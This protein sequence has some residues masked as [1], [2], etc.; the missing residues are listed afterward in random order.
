MD[1]ASNESRRNEEQAP[2]DL[3]SRA[4]GGGPG[5]KI[6]EARQQAGLS[7]GE[8]ATQLRLTVATLEALETDDFQTLREPV[9]VRGYY[10][11]VAK[12][13]PLKE[14]DLIA[15]YD[16]IAAPR[17]AVAAMPSKLLLASSESEGRG[18][19]A[20]LRW[21]LVAVI[22][23]VLIAAGRLLL[24]RHER[25]PSSTAVAEVAAPA[26]QTAVPET[27]APGGATAAA[28]EP[29]AAAPPTPASASSSQHPPAAGP[30]PSAANAPTPQPMS[31][32]HPEPA[33]G[34][35]GS[36]A[37]ASAGAPGAG[38]TAAESAASAPATADIGANVLVL[39]FR[40][41]SWAE[42][43]DASG[44]RLLSG[45]V[46]AGAHESLAGRLPYSVFLGNAPK[47]DVSFGG[48][49]VDLG[50]RIRDNATARFQIP[51]N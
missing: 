50:G 5:A 11:K 4:A 38:A 46:R 14:E 35:A 29:A 3:L 43:F 20:L 1:T 6:R 40:D 12:L 37:T 10:R 21:L 39:D 51:L 49:H 45:M 8:L 17:A 44:K 23:L 13:L 28:S 2:A 33:T 18:P 34:S 48:Q 16:R 19:R 32:A 26:S 27:P 41:Q 31:P 7:M 30:A 22:A 24:L 9:Y 42:V 47:V 36:S 15:A 25:T